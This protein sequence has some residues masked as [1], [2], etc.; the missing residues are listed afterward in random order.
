M[1]LQSQRN[2][3]NA[4]PGKLLPAVDK[5]AYSSLRGAAPSNPGN[6]A[7]QI[8]Y[9]RLPQS[10]IDYF[11]SR[12]PTSSALFNAASP[13]GSRASTQSTFEDFL[14]KYQD[15]GTYVS[16]H[17]RQFD[18]YDK[19]DLNTTFKYEYVSLKMNQL[20]IAFQSVFSHR[21]SALVQGT[22]VQP[23]WLSDHC[24]EM[25]RASKKSILSMKCRGLDFPRR[26]TATTPKRMNMNM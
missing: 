24:L 18:S 21:C 11:T 4:N 23:P 16:R 8:T 3:A 14:Q 7:Q 10:S 13:P 12:P 19:F 17:K 26:T 22:V 2:A 9:T 1:K 6:H 20:I 25:G 5:V 15:H